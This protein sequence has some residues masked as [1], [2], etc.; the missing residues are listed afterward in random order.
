MRSP[1]RQ[2]LLQALVSPTPSSP[3]LP[4]P[5]LV[6]TWSTLSALLDTRDTPVISH[7]RIIV[8][9]AATATIHDLT[10]ALLPAHNRCTSIQD[11]R[12][13][14]LCLSSIPCTGLL[15]PLQEV[16]GVL[17]PRRCRFTRSLCLPPFINRCPVSLMPL[18]PFHRNPLNLAANTVATSAIATRTEPFCIG[19]IFLY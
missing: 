14:L 13:H 9:A 17:R 6:V 2:S 11:L 18:N 10:P 15:P 3:V 19:L 16:R 5:P 8:I 7:T 1:S 12:V 4:N